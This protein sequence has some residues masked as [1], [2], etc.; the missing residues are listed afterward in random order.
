MHITFIAM[1]FSWR[2]W[3]GLG[4]L[5]LLWSFCGG[6]NLGLSHEWGAFSKI[7][8]LYEFTSSK[9]F[10]MALIFNLMLFGL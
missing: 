3:V 5:A 8:M 6:S 10:E 1:E 9:E 7:A 4:W 2:V